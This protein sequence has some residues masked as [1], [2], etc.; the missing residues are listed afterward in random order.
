MKNIFWVLLIA[1][2]VSANSC[3]D[4][5]QEISGGTTNTVTVDNVEVRIHMMNG[6]LYIHEDRGTQGSDCIAIDSS[7]LYPETLATLAEADAARTTPYTA[8]EIAECEK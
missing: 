2:M 6:I 8:E 4:G 7:T 5:K 3:T 1:F